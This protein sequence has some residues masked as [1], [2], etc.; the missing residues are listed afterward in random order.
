MQMH[1]HIHIHTLAHTG[2]TVFDYMPAGA[3]CLQVLRD[4]GA[5]PAKPDRQPSVDG[6][7]QLGQSVGM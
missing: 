7:S 1:T 5:T 2:K 6:Q 3:Q 4:H